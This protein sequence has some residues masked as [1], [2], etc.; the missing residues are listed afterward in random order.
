MID[1]KY[2]KKRRKIKTLTKILYLAKLSFKIKGDVMLAGP[3]NRRSP[4]LVSLTERSVSN[5]S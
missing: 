2:Q 5:Y 1:L 4:T 3:W